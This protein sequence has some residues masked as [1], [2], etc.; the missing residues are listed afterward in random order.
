[1]NAINYKKGSTLIEVFLL[2]SLLGIG[3][4]TATYRYLDQ[5]SRINGRND[6]IKAEE[7]RK[8]IIQLHPVYSEVK[9]LNYSMTQESK[10]LRESVLQ[11]GFDNIDDN[12]LNQLRD[13]YFINGIS[14]TKG[15][16]LVSN[17]NE[18][19]SLEI[20]LKSK[21]TCS[22]FIIKSFSFG[23][24]NLVVNGSKFEPNKIQ[25]N[26]AITA[27]NDEINKIELSFCLSSKNA[28]CN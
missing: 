6:A 8:D 14:S 12:V 28:S 19:L 22:G 2:L 13:S 18:T 5:E 9:P 27:C 3:A 24:A 4:T 21:S 20:E 10:E 23:W 7:L 25:A 1:M 11:N 26:K 15:K 16:V 17:T